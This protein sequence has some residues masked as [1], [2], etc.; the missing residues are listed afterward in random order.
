VGTTYQHDNNQQRGEKTATF[1]PQIPEVGEY[2]VR[3]LYTWYENRS[4]KTSVIVNSADGE[5]AIV[6]N[7][8]KP[9][10]VERVPVA[11]GTF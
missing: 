1:T 5:S 8:R 2:E 3:L 9:C 11:L 10:L 7:Q 6:V 4:T